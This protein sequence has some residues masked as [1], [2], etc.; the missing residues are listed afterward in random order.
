MLML[1]P[2]ASCKPDPAWAATKIRLDAPVLTAAGD[3]V[4]LTP[5]WTAGVVADAQGPVTGFRITATRN[6]PAP[7]L[8]VTLDV[9]GGTAT[10]G[11][12]AVPVALMPGGTA[13]GTIC[14]ASIRNTV[15]SACAP[16][17]AL[18][19]SKTYP[20]LM[21]PPPLN[22]TLDTSGVQ[23]SAVPASDTM[24]VM[25]Q[26]TRANAL[27]LLNAPGCAVWNQTTCALSLAAAFP[28]GAKSVLRTGC[29]WFIPGTPATYAAVQNPP[30]TDPAT[31]WMD[32]RGLAKQ[33]GYAGPMDSTLAQIAFTMTH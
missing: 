22:V 12:I 6:V 27:T 13:T 16:S 18:A 28:T 15:T 24:F 11:K 25:F 5:R 30:S 4:Y 20:V 10:Q 21:P 3:T 8:T 17:P 32:C 1:L 33:I 29:G 23:I 2:L 26:L 19:W 31:R 14:V 7:V 9:T